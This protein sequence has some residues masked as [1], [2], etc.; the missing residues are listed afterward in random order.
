MVGNIPAVLSQ[1]GFST[2]VDMVVKAE[3]AEALS[4][5]GPFTVF[6]P[7][8]EAFTNVDVSTLKALQMDVNL[9]KRVL[10]HHVVGSEIS[11]ASVKSEVT[12]KTLAGDSLR[13]N[14]YGKV[15]ISLNY[16]AFIGFFKKYFN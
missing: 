7:T 14:T 9:L 8:N 2:L 12:P 16:S 5:P 4:G 11:P 6:A 13:I 10:T 15:Y 3:L 1:N